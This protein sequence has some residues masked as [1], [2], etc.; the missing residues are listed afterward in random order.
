MQIVLYWFFALLR[1]CIERGWRFGREFD[2]FWCVALAQ[3]WDEPGAGRRY[4][5]GDA[6]IY[7]YR[8]LGKR[9]EQKK[10]AGCACQ[11]DTERPE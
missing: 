11:D 8:G 9:V 4:V 10:E 3:E 5:G 1:Q 7:A 2:L 6:R